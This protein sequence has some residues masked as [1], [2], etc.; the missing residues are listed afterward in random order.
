MTVN[1]KLSKVLDLRQKYICEFH[2][3]GVRFMDP[4]PAEIAQLT[5]PL[6]KH[7]HE[8]RFNFNSAL[9]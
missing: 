6:S 5:V 7:F 2:L 4:M 9:L 3:W 8:Q 1:S